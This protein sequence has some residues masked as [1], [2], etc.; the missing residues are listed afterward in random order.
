MP[1]GELHVVLNPVREDRVADFERFL[2]D[3]V[4]PAVREQRPDLD[5]RW[6]VFRS[7]TAANGTVTYVI[8]LQGGSLE[9]DWELERLLPGH[10]GQEEYDRLLPEWVDTF[11]ALGPWA[12]AAVEEGSEA[13]QLAWT[14]APVTG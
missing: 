12:D 5:G 6:Q 8:L 10:I 2:T 4:T 3:V 7:T 14:V 13:N 1:D 9:E 11:A